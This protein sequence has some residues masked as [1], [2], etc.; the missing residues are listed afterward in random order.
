MG[1]S[2][3]GSVSWDS[4]ELSLAICGFDRMRLLCLSEWVMCRLLGARI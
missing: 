1:C 4:I 3:L 2:T